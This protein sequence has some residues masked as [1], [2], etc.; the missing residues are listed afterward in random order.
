MSTT[1][2]RQMPGISVYPR[3][4][5]WAYVISTE[6][7]IVSGKR[8]RCF[9][10]GGFDT[11]DEAWESALARQAQFNIGRCVKPSGR[12]VHEFLTEWLSSVKHSL[13]PSTY[14][15]YRTNVEAYIRPTFGGR[16]LRD[17]SVPLLNAFYL[18]LLE[19]GRIKADNNTAMY[20]YWSEHQHLRNGLGPTPKEISAHCGTSIHAARSAVTRYRRG[21]VPTQHSSG[22]SPKSVKN[23]HR[24]LHRAL[25]D[26]M[27]W[28]YLDF[29]PA[30]HAKVPR[31]SRR[32]NRPQPWTV[33]EVASWLDVALQDRFAGM[34]VLAATTG[35]RRSELAGADRNGLDLTRKILVIDETRVVVDGAVEEEDGKS[36]AGE[37]EISLDSFTVAALTMHL[38]MLD[39]E[40]ESFGD[41]YVDSGKLMCWPDGRP[42]HPATITDTFNRLVDKAGVRR[43]RLH[44]VRHSYSTLALDSGVDVKILSDRVGHANPNVTYQIYTHP[45]TGHDRPAAELVANLIQTAMTTAAR[46]RAEETTARAGVNGV[47]ERSGSS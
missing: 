5:K 27:A 36:D 17:V 40:R 4:R 31:T 47:T 28:Q 1:K 10:Q 20:E 30:E 45:S 37:R 46:R 19:S 13:K 26:A 6:P 22:L 25:A 21:R 16:K 41:D 24:M 35:M 8:E 42:L 34:W 29:N 18:R 32:R 14:S 12:T 33:D 15:N 23:I 7:D 3:G 43:I 11:D 2:S 39:T 38:E 9:Y 44:D